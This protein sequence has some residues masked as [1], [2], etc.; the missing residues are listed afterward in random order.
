MLSEKRVSSSLVRNSDSIITSASTVRLFG[1]TTMRTSSALSSRT[2]STSGSFS[3]SI[4]PAI[5]SISRFF[6]TW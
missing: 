3:L 2:S 5:A 4:S 1:S 6:C